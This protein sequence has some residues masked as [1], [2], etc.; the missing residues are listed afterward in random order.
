MLT[1]PHHPISS[2]PTHIDLPSGLKDKTILLI[3]DVP[4]GYHELIDQSEHG[5]DAEVVRATTSGALDLLETEDVDAAV[6]NYR[7][8]EAAGILVINCLKERGIPFVVLA[9]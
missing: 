6:V 1:S 3:E 7:K 4:S 5:A 9:S 8:G 2:L